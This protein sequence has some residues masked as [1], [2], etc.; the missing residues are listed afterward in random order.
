[1]ARKRWLLP[2]L[3]IPGLILL[4]LVVH[5][6]LADGAT[7]SKHERA[8]I[9]LISAPLV[10]Q[11][12]DSLVENCG[13]DCGDD[14][15][16]DLLACVLALLLGFAVLLPI[17]LLTKRAPESVRTFLVRVGSWRLPP[18]L[19]LHELSVSRT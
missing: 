10:S 5:V 1:V 13:G 6:L 8:E 3:L 14:A 15:A 16:G 2:L 19:E 9:T 12:N 11:G 18:S 4:V 17:A 7:T